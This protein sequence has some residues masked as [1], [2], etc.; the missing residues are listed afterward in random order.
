MMP[1]DVLDAHRCPNFNEN[2]QIVI[3][4]PKSPNQKHSYCSRRHK[5]SQQTKVTTNVT[6]HPN[7]S[8]VFYQKMEKCSI[9]VCNDEVTPLICVQRRV[10]HIREKHFSLAKC[11]MMM[12]PLKRFPGNPKMNPQIYSKR[13][14]KVN[15]Q[16]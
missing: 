14:I 1:T 13:Q 16:Y 11:W 3:E 15:D 8:S 10:R 6:V 2:T 5:Q 12:C 7:E 9:A 4:P